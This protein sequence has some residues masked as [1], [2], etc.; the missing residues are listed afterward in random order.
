MG[1]KHFDGDSDEDLPDM[2][3]ASS[4]PEAPAPPAH[5]HCSAVALPSSGS[6]VTP[7]CSCSVRADPS[8]SPCYIFRAVY[9][10]YGQAVAASLSSNIIKTY[11]ASSAELTHAID[12]LGHSAT[13]TDLA[14]TSPAEQPSMLHSSS[15]DGS[16]KGWDLRSGKQVEE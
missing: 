10:P 6:I 12:L 8:K 2:V 15:A 5:I 4:A 11:S 16:I 14:F 3:T 1:H 13:I 9:N 7:H